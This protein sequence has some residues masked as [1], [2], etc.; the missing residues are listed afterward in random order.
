MKIMK[1][2][3]KTTALVFSLLLLASCGKERNEDVVEGYKPI[4]A[5][6]QQL[7]SID[8]SKSEALENPGRIYLYE[9]YLLV[10]DQAKGIHIYDNTDN[11]NP[12]EV[13][14]I[15]IPGNLDFSVNSGMLYADNITDMIIIDISNPASPQYKN[16]I[17]D[18]FPVQQFPDEFGAFECVDPAKGIVVGWEKTQLTNPKCFK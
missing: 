10:N 13:S 1:T 8:V 5:T 6:A 14:F 4:Y 3:I 17:E 11:S 18:V 9:N 15:A 7:E 2:A 16:R 12:K